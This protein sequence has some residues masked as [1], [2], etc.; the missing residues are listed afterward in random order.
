MSCS[1]C[2]IPRHESGIGF[3]HWFLLVSGRKDK[4]VSAN[5]T[6]CSQDLLLLPIMFSSTRNLFS[7]YCSAWY[8]LLFPLEWCHVEPTLISCDGVN[9]VFWESVSVGAGTGLILWG[10]FW[11]FHKQIWSI[12]K[13]EITKNAIVEFWGTPVFFVNV[14][15]V[16]PRLLNPM[17]QVLH[18]N[19]GWISLSSWCLMASPV[20]LLIS[21]HVIHLYSV[22]H[23]FSFLLLA[24]M[25]EYI[26]LWVSKLQFIHGYWRL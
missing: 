20:V 23:L 10:N 3:D 13:V 25:A 2:C 22:I 15:S 18:L 5:L 21:P 26:S 4:S 11:N 19:L 7:C 17:L 12:L 9:P 8:N 14:F 6:V 16:D 24:E 1:G